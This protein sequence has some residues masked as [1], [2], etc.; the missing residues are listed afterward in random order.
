MFSTKCQYYLT[1]FI[2]FLTIF[3]LLKSYLLSDILLFR[4]H[5]ELSV[6]LGKYEATKRDEEKETLKFN[7]QEVQHS[8]VDYNNNVKHFI[9]KAYLLTNNTKTVRTTKQKIAICDL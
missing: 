1:F 6:R 9:A 7:R 5:F 2:F 8:A 3:P 4:L